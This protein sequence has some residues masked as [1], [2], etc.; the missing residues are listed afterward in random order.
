MVSDAYA[1]YTLR[2]TTT[3]T[4]S[5][6]EAQIALLDYGLANHLSSAGFNGVIWG[7]IGI[8]TIFMAARFW[9]RL[10]K[11]GRLAM[12]DHFMLAAYLFLVLNGILQTLQNP[13]IYNVTINAV[14][15]QF[16]AMND[17]DMDKAGAYEFFDRGT[18]FLKYEFTIIGFFWTILWL[19]K[20]SFLAFFYTLFEGLPK[21]RRIWWAVVVFAFL[22]YAGCWIASA[23]TC[24]PGYTYFTFGSWS[25]LSFDSSIL[26]ESVAREGQSANSWIKGRAI[27]RLTS[28]VRSS[29]SSTV[30]W[31][32][33][34][35]ML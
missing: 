19:V 32:T 16:Y 30:P 29:P 3:L 21:Y 15:A 17:L 28:R 20:A 13:D 23:N 27:S 2:N 31:S 33:S 14:R 1:S 24:H 8:A 6:I 22:S 4:V 10:A 26:R 25:P 12:D 18:R 7:G 5:E 34:S 11:T 35:S 9:I